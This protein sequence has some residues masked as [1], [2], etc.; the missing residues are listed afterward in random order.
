MVEIMENN[1]LVVLGMHRSGT[2]LITHWLGRCGLEIGEELLG[3]GIGNIGGHF[4]DA[5][6][7]KAHIDI[8]NELGLDDT[9]IITDEI[10]DIPA[11]HKKKLKK[12]IRQKNAI[13]KQWAWKDPRTCLFLNSY[14]NLLPDARYL[15]VLRDY[16]SVVIS[17]LKRSFAQR[18]AD[19]KNRKGYLSN[20]YWDKVKKKQEF[21]RLCRQKAAYYLEVWLNYNRQ[22]LKFIKQIDPAKHLVVNYLMLKQN[23]ESLFNHLTECWGFAL[24]YAPFSDIYNEKLFSEPFDID[25]YLYDE[26]QKSRADNIMNKLVKYAEPGGA[27]LRKEFGHLHQQ[28][29]V[30]PPLN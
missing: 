18:I 2:S 30:C 22:I 25:A 3:P 17:L 11:S 21:E 16:H 20:L 1:T 24:N 5:D 7:Y 23:D 6:F 10:K 4:E 8:L 27:V 29:A 9:G 15:V 26:K 19:R 28:P 14:S 13:H 12:I